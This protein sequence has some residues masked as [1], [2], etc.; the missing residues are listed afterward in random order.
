V[1]DFGRR[2][3]Y[4][5]PAETERLCKRNLL[6]QTETGYHAN[7]SIE[8]YMYIKFLVVLILEKSKMT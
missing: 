1:D 7:T 4:Y 8:H 6:V 2:T 5:L 3:S